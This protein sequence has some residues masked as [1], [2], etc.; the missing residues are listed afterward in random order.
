MMT[1]PQQ[2]QPNPFKMTI[3]LLPRDKVMAN[4]MDSQRLRRI[5]DAVC[6]VNARAQE[7]AA[8]EP[9]DRDRAY[10]LLLRWAIT[11]TVLDDALNSVGLLM[12]MK[13]DLEERGEVQQASSIELLLVCEA[14]IG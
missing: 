13:E 10:R 7:A 1:S 6:L 3:K 8:A 11:D 5:Q 14:Q 9:E 12:T 4:C 2:Q